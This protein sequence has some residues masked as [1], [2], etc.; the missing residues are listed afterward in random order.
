MCDP[1]VI[2]H[3]E[4]LGGSIKTVYTS[5][6]GLR[7]MLYPE[8]FIIK[9]TQKQLPTEWKDLKTYVNHDLRGELAP[10]GNETISDVVKRYFYI[11]YY[12]YYYYYSYKKGIKHITTKIS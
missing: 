4:K 2:E 6:R 5:Q 7:S 11:F 12:Y 3:I 8:L 10:S 9:P 1:D